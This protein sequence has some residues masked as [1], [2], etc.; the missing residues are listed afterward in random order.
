MNIFLKILKFLLSACCVGIILAL[1]LTIWTARDPRSVS[2]LTWTKEA[3]EAYEADPEYFKVTVFKGFEDRNYSQ[4]SRFGYSRT[5][6][7]DDIDQWQVLLRYNDAVL[8]EFEQERGK[9]D[10]ED[11]ERFVFT[12]Q[13]DL[14]HVYTEYSY[15]WEKTSR[16]TFIRLIFDDVKESFVSEDYSEDGSCTTNVERISELR[17]NVYCREDV[18]NGEYPE[19]PESFMYI[20]G[21]GTGIYDYK[22][23][24]KELPKDGRPT[25]GLC[26]SS[27]LP[28]LKKEEN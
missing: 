19:Y 3:L 17:L 22:N 5:V 4:D 2:R 24:K 10:Y 20:W 9:V 13:D 16:H 8:E 1:I 26:I 25:N 6:K 15:V 14:G 23:L 27:E 12:L 11:G 28:E 18:K 21:D 7:V